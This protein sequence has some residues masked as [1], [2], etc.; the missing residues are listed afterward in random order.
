MTRFLQR[1]NTGLIGVLIA[2][3]LFWTFFVVCLISLLGWVRS[4]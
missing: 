2:D 4:P 3:A 1:F